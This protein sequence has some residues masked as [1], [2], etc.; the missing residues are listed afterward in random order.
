MRKCRRCGQP[1]THNPMSNVCDKCCSSK[2][3]IIKI[4]NR[5][6]SVNYGH[7]YQECLEKSKEK[8]PYLKN[9]SIYKF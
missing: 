7:S 5:D 1:V 9:Y 4:V 8:W 2:T 3:K 6:E